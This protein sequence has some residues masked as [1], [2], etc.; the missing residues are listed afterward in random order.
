MLVRID[1]NNNNDFIIEDLD[2]E[3]LLVKDLK[4][5]ALK[6]RLKE[7]R[8]ITFVAKLSW[9][10]H[11]QMLKDKLKDPGDEVSDQDAPLD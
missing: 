9:S 3:H 10:K 7:V 2:D 4:V 11:P 5:G 1:N 6:A 8:F